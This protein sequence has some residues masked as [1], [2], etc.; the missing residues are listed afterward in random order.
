MSGE[1]VDL[2]ILRKVTQELHQSQAISAD[3]IVIPLKKISKEIRIPEEMVRRCVHGSGFLEMVPTRTRAGLFGLKEVEVDGVKFAS[4]KKIGTAFA[5][6]PKGLLREAGGSWLLS[7]Q[8]YPILWDHQRKVLT[9]QNKERA[10]RGASRPK[11]SRHGLLK[12]VSS[13]Y[14][15]E[16]EEGEKQRDISLRAFKKRVAKGSEKRFDNGKVASSIHTWVICLLESDGKT[17][18]GHLS[19]HDFESWLRSSASSRETAAIC[20]SALR[21]SIKEDLSPDE[22]KQHLLHRLLTSPMREPIFADIISPLTQRATTGDLSTAVGALEQL[23]MLLDDQAVEHLAS[24]IFK[25][26]AENREAICLTL[27][28]MKVPK[29][30]PYLEKMARFATNLKDRNSAL[31]AI[32]SI[33][34][35]SA[36]E[37]IARINH[38][39]Q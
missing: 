9:M 29:A 24:S 23:E 8:L 7:N 10:L 2:A 27:G 21:D 5:K 6:D 25:A 16:D 3:L 13:D 1:K 37:A 33:G 14:M 12:R 11:L 22:Q 39:D 31:D 32:S 26:N 36:Q 34:G 19:N 18:A 38:N 20:S 35:P 28:R 17:I 30:I 4:S 15:K